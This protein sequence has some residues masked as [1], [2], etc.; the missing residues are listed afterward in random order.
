[1]FIDPAMTAFVV[2]VVVEKKS[3]EIMS[4]IPALVTSIWINTLLVI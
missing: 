3:S 1:M 2:V 4:R